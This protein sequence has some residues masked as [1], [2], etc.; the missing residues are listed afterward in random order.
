ML[1]F[2]L[3]KASNMYK[4][5]NKVHF[6]DWSKVVLCIAQLFG[7]FGSEVDRVLTNTDVTLG[8][9]NDPPMTRGSSWRKFLDVFGKAGSSC[10]QGG[11]WNKNLKFSNS[12]LRR[13]CT[14]DW[15]RG[16]GQRSLKFTS[17]VGSH[18]ETPWNFR[19]AKRWGG[20]HDT[21]VGWGG[22][23]PNLYGW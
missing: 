3:R 19:R 13:L 16:D 11:S 12:F 10:W 4:T 14:V 17:F 23:L 7:T 20:C 9:R 22:L 2:C 1:T 6:Y 15:E 5:S 18:C 21:V 8:P